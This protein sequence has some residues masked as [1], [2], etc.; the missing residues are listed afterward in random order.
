MSNG[1]KMT[2]LTQKH[3]AAL[4][5]GGL[6]RNKA[7]VGSG[8]RLADCAPPHP[9]TFHSAA[10]R[11][12]QCHPGAPS[13]V[14]DC[15]TDRRRGVQDLLNV[16]AD[17]HDMRVP[18]IARA[19]LLALGAQLRRIEKS[20]ILEF[21]RMIKARHQS[22]QR[23]GSSMSVPALV[24]YWPP[25][26]SPPLPTRSSFDQGAISRLG[27]DWFRGRTRAAVKTGLGA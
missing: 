26:W 1:R 7:H 2:P 18:E 20:R 10:D 16:V 21:D 8:H 19:C 23:A 11:S 25:L 9:P 27:L 12:D 5:F 22:S 13:R 3:Q 15:G 24:R 14:W 17:P 4:L 6:G